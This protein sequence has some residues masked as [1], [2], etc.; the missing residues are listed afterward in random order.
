[1]YT[2]PKRCPKCRYERQPTDTAPA[3]QCPGCGVAYSKVE[4]APGPT[5]EA[6]RIRAARP[7]GGGLAKWVVTLL[8]VAGIGLIFARPWAGGRQDATVAEAGAAQPEVVMY[9]TSWCPYCAKARTFFQRN[10]IVYVEYDVERDSRAWRENKN[11]GGGGVPTIV[12]GKKIV[13]GYDEDRLYRL[14]GPWI[15]G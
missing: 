9:A 11:Y 15:D 5:R 13:H 7:P 6:V 1:M 10:G 8:A 3:W 12:V 4:T 2:S 14:L